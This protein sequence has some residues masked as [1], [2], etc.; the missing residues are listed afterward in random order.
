METTSLIAIL[1]AAGLAVGLALQG[2]LSNVAAGV[3]LIFLRP[4][5]RGEKIECDKCIRVVRELG[6][7]RTII[8]TDDGVFISIPNAAIFSG[9]IINYHRE[10]MRRT[11]FMVPLDPTE[12]LDR[13]QAIVLA[14]LEAHPNVLRTPAPAVPVDSFSESAMNLAVQAWTLPAKFG[15]TKDDL[16]RQVQQALNRDGTRFSQP[17]RA[18]AA[19]TA[20]KTS[21]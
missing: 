13:V 8:A 16:L 7:F 19:V 10:T 11:N 1:G 18:Q 3:M 17:L 12:N 21:G 20:L 14:V 9:T 6:L 4:F 5:R 15:S 2:T